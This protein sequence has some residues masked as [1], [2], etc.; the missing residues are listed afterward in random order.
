[1]AYLA[2][3]EVDKEK[4][5]QQE[6]QGAT[7]EQVISSQGGTLGGSGAG[8][9][10]S[11]AGAGGSGNFSAQSRGGSAGGKRFTNLQ[12]YLQGN[13]EQ[14]QA[15][16]SNV[17][18]KV[19]SAAQDAQ[20]KGQALSQDFQSKVSQAGEGYDSNLV[21][22]INS[23]Q[24]DEGKAQAGLNA[25][26]NG[27]KAYSDLAGYQDY[28]GAKD[29]AA[30]QV[31]ATQTEQGRG[32]L[33][34]QTYQRPGYSAGQQRL[35]QFLLGG[36]QQGKQALEGVKNQYGNVA[37]DLSKQEQDAQ[38]LVSQRQAELEK[39]KGDVRGALQQQAGALQK[40]VVQRYTD[41]NNKRAADE[42][43]Y[44]FY[45]QNAGNKEDYFR[46]QATPEQ[47]A[48][49][50]AG[51]KVAQ[52]LGAP[53]IGSA[54]YIQAGRRADSGDVTTEADLRKFQALRNLLG[55]DAVANLDITGKSAQPLGD[56]LSFNQDKYSRD[57]AKAASQADYAG[58][59][60]EQRAAEAKAAAK[61]QAAKDREAQQ[62]AL[63]AS[64]RANAD[65]KRQAQIDAEAKRR[66]KEDE[67]KKASGN[68][69]GPKKKPSRA[70][71][72]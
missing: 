24:I 61:E 32:E 65:A 45:Q 59:V 47:L 54:N 29:K 56:A 52:R 28:A 12:S 33:L 44:K 31:A 69:N 38:G 53:S 48:Q 7:N 36:S 14:A 15:M 58:R 3:S 41:V 17:A 40:D 34:R 1:M 60:A 62:A 68:I 4:Q 71:G 30:Q 63:S 64:D 26:Y 9:A 72:S 51:A 21:S 49:Y 19:A 57:Q 23:G 46:S 42:Q 37:S 25:Q 5:Q 20:S 8:S 13:Q 66:V 16:G 10:P 6:G 18:G 43:A 67:A 50:E 2:E 70:T 11:S 35:D 39:Y 22:S 55:Q 27:P